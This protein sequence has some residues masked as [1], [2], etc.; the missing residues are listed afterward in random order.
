MKSIIIAVLDLTQSI[1]VV[2]LA[3]VMA[4]IPYNTTLTPETDYSVEELSHSVSGLITPMPT[5][6]LVVYTV[7]AHALHQ[8]KTILVKK[9][10]WDI[11]VSKSVHEKVQPFG[12]LPSRDKR[13][14]V[15]FT[16]H[17]LCKPDAHNIHNNN[18]LLLERNK[19]LKILLH[20]KSKAGNIRQQCTL[21][22]DA[23]GMTDLASP[24]NLIEI[25]CTSPLRPLVEPDRQKLLREV[26]ATE[27][28]KERK[29]G[30]DISKSK[31]GTVQLIND[32]RK[33]MEVHAWRR[34]SYWADQIDKQAEMQYA[35]MKAG[36]SANPSFMSKTA[37]MTECSPRRFCTLGVKCN[38]SIICYLFVKYFPVLLQSHIN[39]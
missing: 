30:V 38:D 26:S 23:A 34:V 11:A 25:M 6:F 19:I 2:T 29:L 32:K 33:M 16:R 5:E 9:C 35:R 15:R 28:V 37:R 20:Y 27:E 14:T 21:F 12:N 7:L 18:T 8:Y 31:E 36:K 17:L 3:N 4:L 39:N 24:R 1:I 10:Q 22:Q 13:Y